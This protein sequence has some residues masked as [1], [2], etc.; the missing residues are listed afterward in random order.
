LRRELIPPHTPPNMKKAFSTTLATQLFMAVF[1][2]LGAAQAQQ[3]AK[4]SSE[5]P[6]AM[7]RIVCDGPARNAE[8]TINGV[9][10]GECSV[11]VPVTEGSL[12]LRV[13]KKVDAQREQ[14]FEQEI[15]MAAGTVKRLDVEL[16]PVQ[17]NPKARREEEERARQQQALE[18]QRTA[19]AQRIALE[20]ERKEAEYRAAKAQAPALLQSKAQAG[21]LPS[22]LVLAENYYKLKEAAS[23]QQ[24]GIWFRK[25]ADAGSPQGMGGVGGVL[26]SSQN[27]DR[28]EAQAVEWLRRGAAAGDGRSLTLMGFFHA[29]GKA[30]VTKDFKQAQELLFKAVAQDYV[31]AMS[32]LAHYYVTGDIGLARDD[33]EGLNWYRKA[34]ERGDGGAMVNIGFAYEKG[35]HGLPQNDGLALQWYRK[36]AALDETRAMS[37][38]GVFTESGR[39]GIPKDEAAASEW[40][41]K[42]AELGDELAQ[43]N[44]ANN[45]RTGRG[46]PRDE[47]QAVLWYRK[48]AANGNAKAQAYLNARDAMGAK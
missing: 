33:A 5:S 17:A 14:V 21:D 23:L 29:T 26:Y 22:M 27:P 20:R 13:V 44:L 45:Y 8:V 32:F 35:M 11:D 24:A 25:A 16:G 18:A 36:A 12:K 1:C 40:Y 46:V 48:A 39:G 10:K 47:T 19:Q 37:N 3:P 30:G 9:F 6:L 31:P 38:I 7:L 34:A 2:P 43:F 4:K 42:A 41:R 15:R 28:D